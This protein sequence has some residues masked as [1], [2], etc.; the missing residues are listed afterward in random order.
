VVTLKT[1]TANEVRRALD[2]STCSKEYPDGFVL[3]SRCLVCSICASAVPTFPRTGRGRGWLRPTSRQIWG[4]IPGQ[5]PD[6]LHPV[7]PQSAGGHPALFFRVGSVDDPPG[8][9]GLAALTSDMMG[10]G[11]SKKRTYA[12]VLDAL[13]PLAAH[14]QVIGDVESIVFE[15]TV[16]RDNLAAFADLLAE[17]ILEPRFAEDDFSRNRTNALDYLTKTLRGNDDEELG[18][19]ALESMIYAGHPYRHP[20]PGTAAGLA[21]LTLED[22]RQFYGL[23]SRGIA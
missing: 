11:G 10:Q 22:V 15:G 8:K 7:T 4:A 3:T 2:L 6:G 18:K 13:Y 17:Q 21:A 23:T 12:E 1:P 16:H 5:S 20:V 14:I 9:E 19:Q